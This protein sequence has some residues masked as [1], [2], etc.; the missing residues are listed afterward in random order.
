MC[1]GVMSVA[2]VHLYMLLKAPATA[3]VLTPF[4]TVGPGLFLFPTRQPGTW[5]LMRAKGLTPTT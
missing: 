5:I 1:F 3:G 2:H 4:G